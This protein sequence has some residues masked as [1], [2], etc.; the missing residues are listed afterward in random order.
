ML[1]SYGFLIKSCI[2]KIV[3]RHDPVAGNAE[4]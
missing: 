4:V 2:I 1:V 3:V